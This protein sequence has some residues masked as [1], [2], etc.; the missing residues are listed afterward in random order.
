MADMTAEQA[1]ALWRSYDALGEA[2]K[3]SLQRSPDAQAILM[4][5]TFWKLAG[6]APDDVRLRL[7]HLVACF[8]AARQLADPSGFSAGAFLRRALH[9]GQANV[10]PEQASRYRQLVSARDVDELVHRLRRILSEA[11]AEVDWGVLGRDMFNWSD[12]VRR[13]WDK[14][15]YQALQECAGGGGAGRQPR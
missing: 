14:D 9:P 6:A 11:K 1:R 15:F 8:P 12:K 10:A 2:E 4:D 7:A 5:R 3:A 13:A